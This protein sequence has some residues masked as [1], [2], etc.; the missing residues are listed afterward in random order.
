MK[1]V[2]TAVTHS[3]DDAFCPFRSGLSETHCLMSFRSRLGENGSKATLRFPHLRVCCIH[4]CAMCWHFISCALQCLFCVCFCT[5]SECVYFGNVC[6]FPLCFYILVLVFWCC[7]CFRYCI[8]LL[9]FCVFVLHLF[10][11][12][13][14]WDKCISVFFATFRVVRLTLQTPNFGGRRDRP[15]RS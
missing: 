4:V 13:C 8:V 7:A 14:F 1:I 6:V 3:L 10:C 15:S 5:F 2:T 11:R 9:C 12:V